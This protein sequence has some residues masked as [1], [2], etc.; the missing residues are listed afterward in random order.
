MEEGYELIGAQ[1]C[2]LFLLDP[3]PSAD[4]AR[5]LTSMGWKGKEPTNEELRRTFKIYDAD[6]TGTISTL[7]LYSALRKLGWTAELADVEQ[8]VER[9]QSGADKQLPFDDFAKL[10]RTAILQDEV[11]LRMRPGGSRE[12]VLT[13]GQVLNVRD[14]DTDPRISDES[15]RRYQLRGY[16][17]KTLLLAPVYGEDGKEVI[18]LVELVNKC[19][20]AGPKP[21][22]T[23]HHGQAQLCVC[24]CVCVC[25]FVCARDCLVLLLTR[26]ARVFAAGSVRRPAQTPSS[27]GETPSMAST[28]TTSGCSRCSAAIARSSSAILRQTGISGWGGGRTYAHRYVLRCDSVTRGEAPR[29]ALRTR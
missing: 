15:R 24:L 14:V 22:A 4:G 7:E 28:W 29:G 25:V 2:S 19:V 9:V 10:M 1:H 27:C 6:G 12:R 16:D 3:T 8:M 21:E 13:T 23:H 20:P 26:C 5:Y 18:G 17:V 11:R